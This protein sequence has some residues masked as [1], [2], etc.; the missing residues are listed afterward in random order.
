MLQRVSSASVRVNGESVAAI[1]TGL[2]ILAAVREGDAVEDAQRLAHKVAKLR[3]FPDLQDRMNR[4]L[5]EV[6]GQVL[7]VSQFTLYADTRRGRRPSFVEA[8]RPEAAQRVLQEFAQ[9]LR[10]L[11]LEVGEGRFRAH[12]EVELVNDGPVTLILES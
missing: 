1:G 6:G 12:M 9:N 8:A 7:V 11:G 3:I 4:S 5:E 2:V 10:A